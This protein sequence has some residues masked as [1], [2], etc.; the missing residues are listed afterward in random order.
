MN[1]TYHFHGLRHGKTA[2][3]VCSVCSGLGYGT[4]VEIGIRKAQDAFIRCIVSFLDGCVNPGREELNV[5][6]LASL[7]LVGEEKE[8]KSLC[9]A[10]AQETYQACG[11]EPAYYH[12]L[13]MSLGT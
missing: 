3:A 1:A 10:G 5:R 2:V 7:Q 12:M 11:N 8:Y 9:L 13:D 6:S 4:T